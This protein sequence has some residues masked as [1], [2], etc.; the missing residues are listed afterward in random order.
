MNKLSQSA[1]IAIQNVQISKND[2]QITTLSNAQKNAIYESLINDMF[3]EQITKE[4]DKSAA[5]IELNYNPD[6]KEIIKQFSL[7]VTDL[8]E[9]RM[10]IANHIVEPELVSY[11]FQVIDDNVTALQNISDVKDS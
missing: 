4:E 11:M 5:L 1:C 7:G 2:T 10:L 9:T 8:S 3:N 6:V